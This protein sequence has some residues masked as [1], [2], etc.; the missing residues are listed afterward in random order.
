MVNAQKALSVVVA[1]FIVGIIAASLMPVVIGEVTTSTTT[2]EQTEGN[3]YQVATDIE[4][5]IDSIET[6]TATVTVTT[7]D[8]SDTVSV[9]EGDTATASIA[10]NDIDVTATEV[11]ATTATLQYEYASSVGLGGAIGSMWSILPFFIILPVFL[12]ITYMAIN[13]A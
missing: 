9:S 8:G 10:G 6:G 11:G 5:E 12:F 2:L 7:S 1:V 3:T 13:K 4:S